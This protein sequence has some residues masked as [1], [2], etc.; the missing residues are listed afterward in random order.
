M[1]ISCTSCQ[2]KYLVN[3][4]DL[5]PDGRNVQ[6]AKC[7]HQW[8]QESVT[9]Q[10]SENITQLDNLALENVNPDLKESTELKNNLP[11]TYVKETKVSV[12]N[13]IL[14]LLFTFIILISFWSIKN[15][16]INTLVLLKYYINEF[17]FNLNLIIK[18]IAKIV[19]DLLN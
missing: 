5:K 6:C 14:I 11:A 12:I 8:F 17:Y 3:S 4:A 9:N 19:H 16:Q 10:E 2:S 7:G 18:D 1:M 13:S 15:L